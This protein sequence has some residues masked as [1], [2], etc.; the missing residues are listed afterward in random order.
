MLADLQSGL[1]L[2]E[3]THPCSVGET[4]V[5]PALL[6]AAAA[7]PITVR[8]V[9]A[10]AEYDSDAILN[11]ILHGLHAEAFVPANP[12]HLPKKDGFRRCGTQVF[13]PADCPKLPQLKRSKPLFVISYPKRNPNRPR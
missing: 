2:W 3:I 12:T 13:C 5:A 1:P 7:L 4:T 9:C 8:S 11:T 6:E 10:D